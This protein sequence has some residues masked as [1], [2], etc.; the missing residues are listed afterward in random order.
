MIFVAGCQ[1]PNPSGPENSSREYPSPS[2]TWKT[3]LDVVPTAHQEKETVPGPE[4]VALSSEG[5]L[6]SLRTPLLRL[7]PSSM[8]FHACSPAEVVTTRSA[9]IPL[10]LSSSASGFHTASRQTE[11]DVARLTTSAPP[12]YSPEPSLR[13]QPANVAP[14][15]REK[16]FPASLNDVSYCTLVVTTDPTPSFGK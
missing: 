6:P 8:T 7:G 12:A 16:M 4:T 10:A 5:C 1:F 11:P 13:R 9:Q 2:P 3:V 15:K 14:S